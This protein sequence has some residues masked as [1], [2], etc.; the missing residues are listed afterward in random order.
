MS[1]SFG[2]TPTVEDVG[3]LKNF[4]R[5]SFRKSLRISTSRWK[6]RIPTFRLEV[7]SELPFGSHF[8]SELYYLIQNSK[9]NLQFRILERKKRSFCWCSV[10]FAIEN[11]SPYIAFQECPTGLNPNQRSHP[12]DP[13]V[14]SVGS[15]TVAT[16][17][18]P[19][20]TERSGSVRADTR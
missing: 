9:L 14:V 18:S 19:T 13:A 1:Y 6:S 2:G 15:P 17:G 11:W 8:T 5:I 7:T 20:D 4:G 10:C 12:F 3:R 16:V